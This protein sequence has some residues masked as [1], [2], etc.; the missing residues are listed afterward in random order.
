MGTSLPPC[1]HFLLPNEEKPPIL[2]FLRKQRSLS[3]SLPF[4]ERSLFF[5]RRSTR[6]L[7]PPSSFPPPPIVWW[8]G[9]PS[10]SA[11]LSSLS[12]FSSGKSLFFRSRLFYSP[13]GFLRQALPEGVPSRRFCL[14]DKPPFPR[15]REFFLFVGLNH[16]PTSVIKI[17]SSSLFFSVVARMS[18][19]DSGSWCPSRQQES[20]FFPPE[21]RSPFPLKFLD[22]GWYKNFCASTKRMFALP[23]FSL[24]PFLK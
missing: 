23:P 11:L 3:F 21:R 8:I 16:R 14:D 20:L 17:C 1:L 7:R 6:V 10:P 13:L 18:P 22:P 9:S 24:P 12:L 4:H 5:W 15:S 2:P 19:P